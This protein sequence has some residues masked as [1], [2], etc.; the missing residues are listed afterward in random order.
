[1]TGVG[2]P[3]IVS[4]NGKDRP[5]GDLAAKPSG[6]REAGPADAEEA[7][8]AQVLRAACE[9]AGPETQLDALDGTAKAEIAEALR[10]SLPET[11][12]FRLAHP[13]VDRLDQANV[14]AIADAFALAGLREG[15]RLADAG[16]R[17]VAL[18]MD[19]GTC[20]SPS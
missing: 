5:M 8:V 16:E 14:H 1:L 13:A 11:L 12:R 17:P 7:L 19:A 18:P 15:A 6:P 10:D 2:P 3:R 20:R 9:V 4:G